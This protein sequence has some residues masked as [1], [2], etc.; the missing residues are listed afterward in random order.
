MRKSA[1][2]LNV[3]DEAALKDLI[4]NFDLYVL[5]DL[6]ILERVNR[7]Y[8]QKLAENELLGDFEQLNLQVTEVPIE[9]LEAAGV[10]L[11][12]LD[13]IKTLLKIDPF[14]FT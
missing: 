1:S 9:V 11:K 2:F 5:N 6:T 10:S 12:Q 4:E 7:L 14:I 8:R 3:R 13:Q